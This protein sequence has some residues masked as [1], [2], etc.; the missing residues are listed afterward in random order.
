MRGCMFSKDPMEQFNLIMRLWKVKSLPREM[1]A[2]V[3]SLV[4]DE[5]MGLFVET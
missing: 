4:T 5:E 3:C 2:L 1:I